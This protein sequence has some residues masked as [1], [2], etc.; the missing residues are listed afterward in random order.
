MFTILKDET[1][2][3]ISDCLLFYNKFKMLFGKIFRL[4]VM[5]SVIGVISIIQTRNYM[6]HK[7]YSRIKQH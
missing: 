4:P 5:L 6:P 1:K 7:A 3:T 2:C